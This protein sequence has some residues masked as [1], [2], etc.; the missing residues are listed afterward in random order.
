MHPKRLRGAQTFKFARWAARLCSLALLLPLFACSQ[1][2]TDG[3]AVV[4]DTEPSTPD[5][6][7]SGV[8]DGRGQW[9]GLDLVA[10]LQ[11]LHASPEMRAFDSRAWGLDVGQIV[12]SLRLTLESGLPEPVGGETPLGMPLEGLSIQGDAP[13]QLYFREAREV[14]PGSGVYDPLQ[15][16]LTAPNGQIGVGQ[17][18]SM[19]LIGPANLANPKLQGLSIELQW[20]RNGSLS[21]RSGPNIAILDIASRP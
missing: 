13:A 5:S 18:R 16:L 8:F 12:W 14:Q 1:A 17:S 21:A 4:S 20:T 9:K 7:D 11:P 19:A 2:T 15:M 6:A 10:R 3:V